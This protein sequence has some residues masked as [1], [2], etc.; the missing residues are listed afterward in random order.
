MFNVDNLNEFVNKIYVFKSVSIDSFL[1]NYQPLIDSLDQSISVKV[2]KYRNT[3][4][5]GHALINILLITTSIIILMVVIKSLEDE[6]QELDKMDEK[7]K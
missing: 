3:T 1:S 7:P 2:I 4:E 6:N 5:I